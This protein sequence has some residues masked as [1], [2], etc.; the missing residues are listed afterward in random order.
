MGPWISNNRRVLWA[1]ATPT[2]LVL[3]QQ[4]ILLRQPPKIERLRLASAS[5]GPAAVDVQFS[6]PMD[7]AK[8]AEASWLEPNLPHRWLGSGTQL[9]LN[10]DPGEK[11]RSPLLIG[12]GGEDR[13]QQ[14]LMVQRWY[15]DPRPRI[16]AVV[17]VAGGEQLQVRQPN[18]H[19]QPISPVWRDVP[20]LMPLGNGSAV[21][22]ASRNP[23]GLLQL[24]RIPLRQHNLQ[25]WHPPGP[26]P[27]QALAPEPLARQPVVFA[28]LSS[29]RH[30]DLLVQS[31]DLAPE[32]ARAILKAQQGGE[33]EL[34]WPTS[35][36]MQLLPE[37]GAVLVPDSE[38]LHLEALPPHPPRRQSLPGSRDLSSF[39]PQAGRA[40]L[41]RH[42]PD[43]RRSLELVEPGLAPRQLWLGGDAVLASACSR[44]GDTVWALLLQSSRPPQL[45]LVSLNR[46]GQVL[47]RRRLDGWE[48]EPGS[49]LHW[50]PTTGQ[51]LMALRR[52]GGAKAPA[53]PTR[54][55][56]VDTSTMALQVLR[57]SIRQAL[58]LPPG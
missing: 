24:W 4:Q 17:V 22:T 1:L 44:G 9:Q 21:V 58:W 54:V 45:S 8:V 46:Q 2:L 6:R 56:L 20:L 39:C 18:G 33:R 40:V 55:V 15:W 38:G 35:G 26:P 12:L 30:G 23:D 43:F 14:R 36:P 31:G 50:D 42:W 29:N 52:M 19:W 7:L 13:R 3:L 41:L 47:N 5:A 57:P 48:L 49:G 32:S 37:G 51:L 25:P 53:A 10:L 27:L 34:P 16:L 11:L 28:H